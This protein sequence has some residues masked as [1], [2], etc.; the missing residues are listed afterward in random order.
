MSNWLRVGCLSQRHPSMGGD[1]VVSHGNDAMIVLT[2]VFCFRKVKQREWCF[3]LRMID[4]VIDAPL[5]C[6]TI[7]F[8]FSLIPPS[9]I[10]IYGSSGIM[11]F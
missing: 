7:L 1:Y 11:R 5:V 6:A 2:T 3:P 9:I 4:L 10:I 8:P